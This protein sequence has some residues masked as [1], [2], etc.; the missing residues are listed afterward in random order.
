MGELALEYLR[1][2]L[3]HIWVLLQRRAGLGHGGTL[4]LHSSS[5]NPTARHFWLRCR[6]TDH[7]HE[8]SDIVIH[9][10]CRGLGGMKRRTGRG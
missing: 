10:S 4:L 1:S 3:H 8:L 7:F 5:V 2:S 6:Q 9:R